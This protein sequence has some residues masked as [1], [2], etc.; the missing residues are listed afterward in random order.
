MEKAIEKKVAA[1]E[2]D[3]TVKEL[4][5]E[6]VAKEKAKIAAEVA[7]EM[8][9]A[10]LSAK[11][12]A[13]VEKVAAANSEAKIEVS[14]A[15]K[16]I[17][18]YR[19]DG[20]GHRK[21]DQILMR[22]GLAQ[23]VNKW[24]GSYIHRDFSEMTKLAREMDTKYAHVYKL[25]PLNETTAADGGNLVPTVLANIIYNVRE[26]VG[27]IRPLCREVQMTSHTMDVP[28][29]AS[30][31]YVSWA[32]EQSEKSTSSVQFGKMTLTA[33]VLAVII[34]M[35]KQLQADAPFN[36][37][38]LLAELFGEAFAREEDRTFI[39]GAGTTQPTGI[40]N[41][42]SGYAVV[43]AG[44]NLSWDSLVTAYFRLSPQYRANAVWVMNS[45]R[46]ALCNALKDSQNRPILIDPLM[47]NGSITIKGRPVL[48]VN[49]VADTRIFL[50]DWSRYWIGQREGMTI[51]TSDTTSVRQ[52]S[53]FETNQ[54]AFRAEER[55]DGQLIDTKAFTEIQ[56]P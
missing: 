53:M 13:K 23:M 21:G 36:L 4:A 3:K 44:A 12:Q 18:S 26:D 7:Q 37:P 20:K 9:K 6:L 31:P 39:N 49:D 51:D 5:E 15:E 48:E 38:A 8:L 14:E 24:V 19:N 35:T 50:V 16:S 56:N 30:K 11:S 55:L 42:V 47:A 34:T 2:A 45:S 52:V 40:E 17:Y 54:V 41:Y 10:E 43:N 25:E 27:K 29:T 1:K 33:N 32:A 22:K 46:V 28:Y